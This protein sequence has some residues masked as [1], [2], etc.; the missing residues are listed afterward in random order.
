MRLA[1]LRSRAMR[2]RDSWSTPRPVDRPPVSRANWRE[3][4]ARELPT[5]AAV[6]VAGAAFPRLADRLRWPSRLGGRRL[7]VYIA[8]KT[9]EGFWVRQWL[10]P[11]ITRHVELRARL[12]EQLGREP[13]VDELRAH[14]LGSRPQRRS[15]RGARRP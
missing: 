7:A 5:A 9:L 6:F 13:T 4:I 15:G 12:V 14:L 10:M 8:F 11:M 3:P 1:A 2:P